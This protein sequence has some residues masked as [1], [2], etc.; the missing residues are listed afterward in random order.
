MRISPHDRRMPL[1]SCVECG[2]ELD[3]ASALGPD[4]SP[5]PGDV[6]LCIHCGSAS[7]FTEEL[8]LRRPTAEEFCDISLMPGVAE[9]RRLIK[10]LK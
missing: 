1:S 4:A 6:T 5:S 2:K 8:L 7:I 3:G 9:F 10:E